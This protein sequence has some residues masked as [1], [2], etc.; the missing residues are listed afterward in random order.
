MLNFVASVDYKNKVY[1][2]CM[3]EP[4]VGVLVGW[5]FSRWYKNSD[6]CHLRVYYLHHVSPDMTVGR[7]ILIKS[8]RIEKNG[9]IGL[10]MSLDQA[11]SGV[12]LS[13]HIYLTRK[14]ASNQS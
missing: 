4:T 11:W 8:D 6:C 10:G 7:V 3:Q 2:L 14:Q 5:F 12:H 9:E 1:A 13:T